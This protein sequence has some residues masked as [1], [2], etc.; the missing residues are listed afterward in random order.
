MPKVTH[1]HTQG[2]LLCK[3]KRRPNLSAHAPIT[4]AH[5]NMSINAEALRVGACTLGND[6]QV[7]KCDQQTAALI[8]IW[9]CVAHTVW[10]D[11]WVVGCEY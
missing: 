5:K 6:E 2:D 4:T 10:E 11:K 3:A 1:T 7:R 9:V 8:F